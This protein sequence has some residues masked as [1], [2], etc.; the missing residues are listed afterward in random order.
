MCELLLYAAPQ[1]EASVALRAE[2]VAKADA[3][4]AA[5]AE[6]AA[7]AAE[8]AELRDNVAGKHAEADKFAARHAWL[9][10]RI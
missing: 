3:L 10:E 8:I 9:S 4:K 5:E 1:V 7:L 6:K 2:A